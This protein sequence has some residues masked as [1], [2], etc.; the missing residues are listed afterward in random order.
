MASSKYTTALKLLADDG[1]VTKILDIARTQMSEDEAITLAAAIEAKEGTIVSIDL[2]TCGLGG[3]GVVAICQAAAKCVNLREL[4]LC[5]NAITNDG[6]TRVAELLRSSPTLATLELRYCRIGS[7]G[8]IGLCGAVGKQEDFTLEELNLS[9]NAISDDAARE[10]AASLILTISLTKLNLA[11]TDIQKTGCKLLCDSL[12]KSPV[13]EL[14]LPFNK[15]DTD[16]TNSL[17][18]L[19]KSSSKLTTLNLHS[20]NIDPEGLLSLAQGVRAGPMRRGKLKLTGLDLS[21]VA[22]Q[23]QLPDTYAG[24]EMTWNTENILDF[25]RQQI[26]D[27]EFGLGSRAGSRPATR[28]SSQSGK[29]DATEASAA[30]DEI[31]D[32]THVFEDAGQDPDEF[33]SVSTQ[34]APDGL[35]WRQMMNWIEKP[36]KGTQII[37]QDL[38]QALS[39]HREHQI[40]FTKEEWDEFNISNLTSHCYI[41]ADGKF[42]KPVDICK[43]IC[44]K[45]GGEKGKKVVIEDEEVPLDIPKLL[46][47]LRA[48]DASLTEVSICRK[49]TMMA[50]LLERATVCKFTHPCTYACMHTFK[51]VHIYVSL[52]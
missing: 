5:G 35:H 14:H 22:G 29:D 42:F 32:H 16:M 31:Q 43:T 11:D 19:L 36:K 33:V 10:L 39:G 28:A 45:P 30:A 9:G 23:L 37:N 27:R 6:A 46:E 40:D 47:L 38:E 50:Q 48:N 51:Y 1:D 18:D 52:Y 25:I 49:Y 34:M 7:A 41:V 21:I 17:A 13:K 15:M 20:C 24:Q 3:P 26:E 12:S 44:A 2:R 4:R 8:C